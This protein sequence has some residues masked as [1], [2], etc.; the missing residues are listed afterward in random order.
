MDLVVHLEYLQAV[1]QEFDSVTAL[2][3]DT[4]VRYFWENLQPSI[5]A[6]LDVRDRDLNS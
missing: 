5:R 1:F 3:K 4:M 2:N 6:Q